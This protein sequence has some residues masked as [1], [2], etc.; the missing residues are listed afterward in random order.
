[1]SEPEVEPRAA[2]PL[3]ETIGAWLDQHDP[4]RID[5]TRA[6]HL[7][8]SYSLVIALGY[9]TSR[10]FALGLDVIF[11]MAGAMTALVL[12]LSTPAANRRAE[13]RD[14]ARAFGITFSLLIVVFIIGPGE[15]PSN[16]MLLKLLLV[17]FTG[18][19]LYVRRFG[20]AGQRLGFTI[21]IILTVAAVLHPTRLEMTYLL[22]ASLQG[23]VV[24]V[25]VRLILPRPDAMKVYHDTVEAAGNAMGAFLVD[26]AYCVRE[27]KPLPTPSEY[28]LDLTRVR[29]RAALVNASAQAP[30]A[31]PYIEAVRARAYRLRIASQLLGDSVPRTDD[32]KAPWRLPFA[33]AADFI[34]RHLQNGLSEPF[35]E[36]ARM[37][38]AIARFRKEAMSPDMDPALQLSLLRSVT[39]IDRIALVVGELSNLQSEGPEVLRQ[40]DMPVPPSP[41]TAGGLSQA[42][43][44]AIQGMV[45]TTITTTLDFVL[46]LNHAYWA[47]MTVMFVLGNSLG[48]TYVRARYRSV[49]TVIGVIVGFGLIAALETHI[50]L[51]AGICLVGQMIGLVTNRDRYDVAS[52]ATGLSILIALHLVTG[53][54]TDGM[55]ARIYETVIGAAVALAA[56]W[57][58]LPVFAADQIR[59]QV[60]D[61]VRRSRSAFAEAWPRGNATTSRNITV[62]MTLELRG[63]ADRLPQIGAETALG[64]RS[65]GDVVSLVS[66]LEVLTTY[67]GLL[68]DVAHRLARSAPKAEIVTALEAARARTLRAFDA[69]L[70]DAPPASRTTEAS[71][72]NAALSTALT[73]A[74]DPDTRR[75]LPLVADYLSFSDAVL[76]PLHDVG[77]ILVPDKQPPAPKKGP[78]S[79]VAQQ[80]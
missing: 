62:G 76:R 54:G 13:A 6:L 74:P 60:I 80:G 41:K 29:V 11:P 30:S 8:V 47:T 14:F 26:L 77:T 78:A 18:L 51:L 27:T 68:E 64:H 17:P 57:L 39:A 66:T 35:P 2:R 37:E 34:A 52:A 42:A 15:S 61:L 23:A 9:A 65:A 44:V 5:T 33:T 12:V 10:I 21:V 32:A 25:L 67:L 56:S 50:W 71:E 75:I 49:G 16:G 58:I 53:L 46:D 70:G 7:A 40:K 22:A 28:L 3:L 31:R 73:N 19:A 59:G 63:L 55:V 43:K 48:E 1:M 36:K 69:A 79:A 24:T 38:E 45:A 72:L 20:M 4:G